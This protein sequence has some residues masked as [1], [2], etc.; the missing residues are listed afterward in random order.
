MC[1]TENRDTPW[2]TM[3]LGYLWTAYLVLRTDGFF[4]APPA[5]GTEEPHGQCCLSVS[6]IW[7]AV[8]TRQI[9]LSCRKSARYLHCITCVIPCSLCG[10]LLKPRWFLKQQCKSLYIQG[11]NQCQCAY[12]NS[13]SIVNLKAGIF[14]H[15][16]CKAHVICA[17]IIKGLRVQKENRLQIRVSY[18]RPSI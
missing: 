18:T 8:W 10:Y 11:T 14:F 15:A 9:N 12:Y 5:C 13:L 4:E 7:D 17:Y 16:I 3:R 2:A 6:F 1:V